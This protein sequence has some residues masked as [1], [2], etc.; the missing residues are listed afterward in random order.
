MIVAI[1]GGIGSGKSFICKRLNERGIQVYDCDFHAKKLLNISRELQKAL[2]SLVGKE[3]FP[4]GI[5]QK[6][7]LASY[8]L[9]S[10][11]HM[12]AVN[13]I[14]HPAVALDFKQSGLQWLESAIL[15]DSAFDKRVQ[16]DKVVC[17]TAPLETRIQR[18]M[19]RDNITRSKAEKWI[20]GQIPQ[21]TIIQ[22]SD[23]Q[24]INDGISNLEEQLDN[25][26]SSLYREE[27][28]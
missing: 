20:D 3:L 11:E 23:Y 8:I 13:N 6:A 24:I 12:V 5:F 25:V 26:L 18:I 9:E 14:I 15:F 16:I 1:T 19:E 10:K 22:L 4:G 27:I 28:I 2:S 7:E 17:I 21:D